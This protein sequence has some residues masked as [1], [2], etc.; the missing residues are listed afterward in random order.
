MAVGSAAGAPSAR[1]FRFIARVCMAVGIF[2]ES[3]KVLVNDL[4]REMV[5]EENGRRTDF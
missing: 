4:V 1:A 5:E 2:V 3:V